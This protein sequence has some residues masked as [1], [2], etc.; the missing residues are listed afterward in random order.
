MNDLK[1]ITYENLVKIAK[2]LGYKSYVAGNI[3][4]WVYKRRIENFDEMTD[5]SKEFRKYLKDKFYISKLNLLEKEKSKDST[6]KFLFELFDK[7]SI[8]SVLIPHE[9]RLTVCVSTQVGCKMNCAFCCTAKQGFTRNLETSEIVNQILFI[10]DYLKSENKNITNVV[11]MGMGEPLDNMEN[12]I[13]AI[14]IISNDFSIGFGMRKIT[15]STSGLIDKIIDFKKK[16]GA[17]LAISLNSADNTLRTKL[18]PVNNKYPL[19]DLIKTIKTINLKSHE[20]VTIEY[21]MFKDLN[22]SKSDAVN[23]ANLLKNLPIKLNLIPFNPYENSPFKTP[24]MSVVSDFYDYL[25]SK[26]IICNVR[27]S[28]GSDISAACGQLKSKRIEK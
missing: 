15:V 13:D 10:N 3:F 18:M 2:E 4:T 12:V 25:A 27:H 26:G 28:R 7:E 20:F 23:L 24:S 9:G 6:I 1:S 17:R 8:E 14:A 11:F 5:I 21:I 19:K 16:C 22:D